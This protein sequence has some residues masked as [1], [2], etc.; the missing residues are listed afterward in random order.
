LKLNLAGV[1][2]LNFKFL[3]AKIAYIKFLVQ[4]KLSRFLAAT[5]VAT[6]KTSYQ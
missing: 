5:C 2:W 6:Y 1:F 3:T 4:D